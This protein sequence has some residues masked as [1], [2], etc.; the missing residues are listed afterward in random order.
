MKIKIT[1]TLLFA[2]IG[3]WASA[4]ISHG[5]TPPSFVYANQLS[6]D[7]SFVE[8][9][10]VNVDALI[11]ED[12]LNEGKDIPYR[13]GYNHMV[14]LTPQNSGNWTTLKKGDKVW[15][16]GIKSEG[17]Y[18]INI[19]FDKFRIPDGAQLFVYNT[20]RSYVL[21]S[22]TS[23]NVL[24][25]GELGIDLVP[26]QEIIVEYYEPAKPAFK[27]ELSIFRVTHAYRDAFKIAKDISGSGNCHNNVI[28]PVGVPWADQIRS[29]AMMVV[30][31]NGFCTG[32]LVNNTLND[33]K[34]YFLS[35]YHCGTNAN[36]WVFR[37][38]YN[39]TNCANDA[40]GITTQSISG[41]TYRAG[42]SA[43]DFTLFELSSTPPANYGVYY[44]GWNRSNIAP[45]SGASIHHPSGDLKKISFISTPFDSTQW[46]GNGVENHWFVQWS[47]GVTEGGSSGSP[48]Y[49]Q[50]KRVVGQ[51]HGGASYCGAPTN[52]L[53]DEY[54][55]F[56]YSW[57]K[58]GANAN[59][60]L[61]P[62]LDP[63]NSGAITID[64]YDPNVVGLPPVEAVSVGL[65]LPINN[66]CATSATPALIVQNGGTNAITSLFINWTFDGGAQQNFSVNNL[67]IA[68]GATDT[69]LL[70]QITFGTGAHTYSTVIATVN[71][72][73]DA[74]NTNNSSNGAFTSNTGNTYTLNLT[75]DDYGNET[76]AYIISLQGDTLLAVD[77]GTVA[78]NTL[79]TFSVCLPD[80]C[81]QLV[82]N[83]AYGDGMCCNY[84][85]GSYELLNPSSAVIT[86]GGEFGLTTSYYFCT[87]PAV[88]NAALIDIDSP[89]G[90][91]CS[92]KVDPSFTIQNQGTAPITQ[93]TIKYKVDNGTLQTYAWTGN[94]AAGATATITL[95]QLT[96]TAG[97]HTFLVY[98]IL[99]NGLADE[100]PQ[101]DTLTTNFSYTVG[102]EVVLTL[103]T[104]QYPD[105][106]SWTLSNN[107]GGI[108]YQSNDPNGYDVEATY[109]IKFCL[110]DG[111]YRFIIADTE[112]D[113]ICCGFGDGQFTITGPESATIGNG[114]QFADSD[115]VDFCLPLV[116]VAENAAPKFTVYPNPAAGELFIQM[117]NTVNDDLTVD[118]IN[119]Q[120]QIVQTTHM[121]NAPLAKMSVSNVPSGIYLVRLYG[122]NTKAAALTVLIKN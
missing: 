26:G 51:L 32:S 64:G 98:S 37:F 28:C 95:P 108:V 2:A 100:L 89:V 9:P 18:S 110:P 93:L 109:N 86:T 52:S 63:N 75:G 82:V 46:T 5:G 44:A 101:N 114:G 29:V 71:G 21:G 74:N 113:G 76:S 106:T 90:E 111:C 119:A 54:G 87:T 14:N 65:I 112:G 55:K 91:Y 35:A 61:K 49:D 94:L 43:S 58:N 45:T 6:K 104:D 84:G 59:Q 79:S 56:F 11:Q 39:S 88:N 62:W 24:P 30:N 115:T 31:G 73:V 12:N 8:M 107:P 17:A 7:V 1:L 22:F 83:D 68:S 81:Y 97:N 41:A 33:G 80:G 99:P 96:V 53:N 27:G 19:A 60:R 13:F 120:G 38:N 85:E 57:D 69:I 103:I 4:Q 78:N 77:T 102:A 25:H 92:N 67:S 70:P 47:S 117:G 15:R 48:L 72:V 116:G 121:Q 40:G 42:A 118:L 16:L 50:N 20:D 66:T 34:P 105:E 3:F 122:Q 23:A 36:N 10:L